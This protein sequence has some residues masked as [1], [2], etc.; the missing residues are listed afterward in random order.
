M[1][2]FFAA[3][4]IAGTLPAGAADDVDPT[5]NAWVT[6]QDPLGEPVT[7]V[8]YLKQNWSPEESV[9][10]YFTP[11]GSQLIPYDWF[12]ALEQA[13]STTPFHDNQ[14][15]LKFR[16][17]PQN[18]G[19]MNPDGLPVGFVADQGV[20]RT[21]LG[22]TCAACHTTEIRLGT[23]AYRVDGAPTHAD[24]ESFLTALICAM[25]QTQSDSAK[26][27]R[28]AAAVLGSANTPQNQAEL[29]AQLAF[30]IK[31]RVGYNLRNFPGYN[32]NLTAPPPTA[33]YGR[34]DA[35]DA[36]VNEVFWHAVDN[37]DLDHPTV[38]SRPADAPVSYPFLWDTP[39]HDRVEW[40]GIAKSGGLGDIFSL[41]RNV[42]EVLGVFGDFAIPDNPSLLNVGYPSSIKFSN[43]K[44]LED[45]VK[46]LWSPLWP[47]E[48][49]K[50]DRVAAA[51][52][53]QLYKAKL[54]GNTSCYDCHGLIDRTSPTRR[55]T[56]VMNDAHTDSRA[57]D[58]FFDTTR[59]SGKLNGVNVNFIPFTG[60]IPA[61]AD[62]NTMVTHEV[63][64]VILGGFK[65]AP[66]D[67]LDQVNFRGERIV[68]AIAPTAPAIKYKA[69]SLNGIWATA[70]YLHN[71]SVPTLDA[72]LQPAE[73]RPKSFSIGVRTFDPV[74]VGYLTDVPG[75][76]K[77]NV[78]NPDGTPIVGNSN[79][80]HDYGTGL[81]DEERRQLIEYLK[82]L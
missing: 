6:T 15:I 55:V 68:A 33:H 80:G 78:L 3:L 51:K 82:S 65:E 11:Q 50:I 67:E 21:W 38:V 77:F 74:R 60:K 28:F 7:N 46:T 26:F 22:M 72:L 41:S 1:R 35:V 48:F 2:A 81:S 19:P 43:L 17:L 14:N 24:V 71:G 62:A 37:P 64:G 20:G 75:F 34:L 9:R 10:F 47:D 70:P 8:V 31:T 58:N 25:Q 54:N 56:A 23:T 63:I 53:A 59:P 36:I 76:P 13:G 52:G 4:V 29:K 73:K 30:S 79:A 27:E 42:G 61:E 45:L 49:P 32:P 16:Y 57:Y 44:A 12:L 40:L 66:P 5:R 69:R 39:Q 18:P